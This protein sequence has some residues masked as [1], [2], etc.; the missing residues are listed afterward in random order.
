MLWCLS[1]CNWLAQADFRGDRRFT[2]QNL[3][4][5]INEKDPLSVE[6][7]KYYQQRRGIPNQNIIRVSFPP[8]KNQISP[9]QFQQIQAQVDKQL[10]SN[11]QGFALTWTAPFRVQ[12]MS[13]TSAFALGYDP[14]YCAQGCQPTAPNAYFQ[15]PSHRPYRDF[16]VRPTMM[17]AGKNF[18]EA[19]ALIDRGVHADGSRPRGTAYL[20]VTKDKARNVRSVTFGETRATF[21]TQFKVEIIEGN[22]L[23]NRRDVMFYFTGLPKVEKLETLQFRPGAIADHLTSFGGVLNGKG[24]MSSLRWLE[25]GATGSYGTV[26]E[27]CNFPQK[28]PHVP[29][30]MKAYLSGATL[31][32][33]Y[34]Q[35]VFWPGQGIFIGEPLARPFGKS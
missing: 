11:I 4:V 7:G 10:S 33:S 21:G 28:F 20:L 18:A 17:I 8:T 23:A 25:A 27:P 2:A 19:K 29:S 9:E 12:C 15:N 35:S 1:G 5:I 34:W 16:Q 24:Q 14:V 6:V 22:V 26:E 13:I 3:G 30:L 31:L 32:E